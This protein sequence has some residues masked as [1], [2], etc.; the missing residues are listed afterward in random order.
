MLAKKNNQLG[1]ELWK[2]WICISFLV[3]VYTKKSIYL[4]LYTGLMVIFILQ[5]LGMTAVLYGALVDWEVY[6]GLFYRERERVEG[7]RAA[8]SLQSAPP[9]PTKQQ[10]QDTQRL[11]TEQKIQSMVHMVNLKVSTCNCGCTCRSVQQMYRCKSSNPW[12]CIFACIL[13]A[14]FSAC[15]S[16]SLDGIRWCWTEGYV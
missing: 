15:R 16:I 10:P 8:R 12:A 3:C 6:I 5:L 2:T 13:C 1:V 14:C 7:Q 4:E 11:Y 9:P